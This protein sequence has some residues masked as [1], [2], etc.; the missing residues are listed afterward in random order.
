MSRADCDFCDESRIEECKNCKERLKEKII[1][2][3]LKF[4]CSSSIKQSSVLI[5]RMSFNEIF[6]EIYE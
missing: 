4:D 5:F 2:K 6:G 3:M 1:N